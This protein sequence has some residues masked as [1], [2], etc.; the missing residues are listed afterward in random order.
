MQVSC[1]FF[2]ASSKYVNHKV[3]ASSSVVMF[4]FDSGYYL[5]VALIFNVQTDRHLGTKLSLPNV[6]TCSPSE[7]IVG[8]FHFHEWQGCLLSCYCSSAS[9]QVQS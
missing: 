2:K 6:G 3:I 8:L 1:P 4:L 5:L 7:G 9:H